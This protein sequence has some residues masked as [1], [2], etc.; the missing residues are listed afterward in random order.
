MGH[1]VVAACLLVVAAALG[2][3]A[4]PAGTQ[5]IL[6]S[7]GAGIGFDDLQYSSTL[8]RVLVPAGRAGELDLIDPDAL[9]VTAI[10]GFSAAA[11]FDGGH[12]DGPTSVGE[13]RGLLFVTDRTS[14]LLSVV[15]PARAVIVAQAALA[16]S[17]DYVRFVAVNN[18]LWVTEPAAAQIEIFSLPEGPAPTPLPVAVIPVANGPESLVIDDKTGRAFTHRWQRST[19][20]LDVRSRAVLAEWENGCASSRGI[21]L[22]QERGFLF[23]ACSE[24]TVSVLDA[25]HD[26]RVL[27]VIACGAG[28]DV[29]GY[30]RALGHLYL[31]GSACGCLIIAGVSPGGALS[32]LGRFGAPGAAH[33]A[34]ADDRGNAWV[35]DQEAGS[36]RRVK[37]P[38]PATLM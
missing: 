9:A 35:C 8:A 6:P 18:E 31:A 14:R 3:C 21:G 38:F 4:G 24:G 1:T 17:P 2:S 32:F 13:G 19:V 30:N 33:C 34:V 26:G 29:I 7:A 27:S 12:D 28:F 25:A 37:D 16:A 5:V 20:V 15:D 23:V 10:K 36:L 11:S 22:D